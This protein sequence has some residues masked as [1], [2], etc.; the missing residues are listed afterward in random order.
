MGQ[1]G[2]LIPDRYVREVPNEVD[3]NTASIFWGFSLCAAVF[4]LAKGTQQSWRAW[5]RRH[6]A[7]AYVGMIWVVWLS[8]MVLGCLAWGFQRQ[9]IAP[10]FGFYFSVALFWALQVQFLLQIIIN[11][12]GLLMVSKARAIRLKWTVFLIILLVNISV[13]VIWMPARLQI[14]DRWIRLN[15]IWD[16]CEKVI[17]AVVDGALNGYFIYLVRSRLI[18]N[19]LTK[20]I[21]LYRMNLGLIGLSLSL[22]IVLVGL[23]SLPSSLVYL[24]FHPVAYLLKLQ[25]EM[26]MAEL[27]TKIV[28]SSGTR[29][30]DEG[31][32]H[33]S[34]ITNTNQRPMTSTA[35]AK[36]DRPLTG[37][38]GAM[39]GRNTTLI[40][41]GDLGE[42]ESSLES[43]RNGR[44]NMSGIVRTI[45]TTVNSLPAHVVEPSSPTEAK[46]T[47]DYQ[48]VSL[49]FIRHLQRQVT[50]VDA[51][52]LQKKPTFSQITKSIKM[53]GYN[54]NRGALRGGRGRGDSRRS[55]RHHPYSNNN[56][57]SR[58]FPR[59]GSKAEATEKK[60]Y[61]RQQAAIHHQKMEEQ[62]QLFR[63]ACKKIAE[64]EMKEK[65]AEKAEKEEDDKK[66]Q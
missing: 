33:S 3:M 20:Y 31:Y 66:D 12:I 29:G 38:H 36:P 25:I 15:S 63:N 21:P 32:Y 7:T 56:Q 10:S 53:A 49:E 65:E 34:N 58:A 47:R 17:F 18:E 42:L 46:H 16:R 61:W 4:T 48:T 41:G 37:M 55:R 50:D 64:W 45:E 5:K 9:Y 6:R 26:K 57:P 35:K 28:R 59:P 52:P 23:M 27:I 22:D 13:F 40:E 14:N 30:S 1:Y 19:G 8:S 60:A 51:F 39:R 43:A 2:Y 44:D 11:R 62:K 54:N 24:S